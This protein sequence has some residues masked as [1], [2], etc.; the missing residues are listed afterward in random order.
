MQYKMAL[1]IGRFQPFHNGHLYS[2]KKCLELAESVIVA[3]GSSQESGTENNP[4][5]FE[6]RKKMVESLSGVSRKVRVVAIPD[7]FNDQRWGEQI[8]SLIK[9]AGY[10]PDQVVGVGN[11]DWTNRILKARGIMVYETGF[12]M[13][14]ELEGV[15]IRTLLNEGD[16]SWKARVPESVVK[17]LEEYAEK[18]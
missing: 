3:V 9:E 12:Y 13:R 17:Y 6:T 4:W 11:N 7:L 18:N 1:F 14:D 10:E 8:V 5:D 15:K 16:E 2:L